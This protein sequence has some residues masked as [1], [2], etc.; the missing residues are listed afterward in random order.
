MAES[1][2]EGF[3]VERNCGRGSVWTKDSRGCD[4][5]TYHWRFHWARV[6]VLTQTTGHKGENNYW[7]PAICQISSAQIVGQGRRFKDETHPK[8]GERWQLLLS[9]LTKLFCPPNV[10]SL[11]ILLSFVPFGRLRFISCLYCSHYSGCFKW[12]PLIA[13]NWYPLCL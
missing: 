6:S 9:I 2:G 5:C 11:F 12:S 7:K 10:I 8:G 3:L 4:Y 13:S 1:K